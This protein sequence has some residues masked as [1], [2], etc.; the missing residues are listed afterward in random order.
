MPVDELEFLAYQGREHDA[1]TQ[2]VVKEARALGLD[3]SGDAEQLYNAI[4]RWGE[5]LAQLRIADPNPT[6]A[7]NALAERRA[8]YPLPA[9]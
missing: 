5:E 9:E 4:V 3:L 1:W 8:D 6:H 2:G 7:P